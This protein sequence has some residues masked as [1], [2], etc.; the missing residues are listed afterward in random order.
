M[1]D[2]VTRL[3]LIRHAHNNYLET[4]RL[5][6]RTPGVHLDEQG[7]GQA[8]ALARRL[9]GL[10]ISA[11]YS[12]PLERAIETLQP[13]A[14]AAGLGINV[15]EDLIETDCGDW[16]GQAIAT[17]AKTE[18]GPRCRRIPAG[19]AIPA[20]K[21]SWRCKRAWWRPSTV[22]ARRMRLRSSPSSRTPIRSK[23][24]WRIILGCTWISFSAW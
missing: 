20:A 13:T 19:R 8:Q 23:R 10:P 5:A 21:G 3:L 11:I 1:S 14:A 12:S 17:L 22:S 9:A 4:G 6:G 24:R 2:S 18:S 15:I 16:T 7:R